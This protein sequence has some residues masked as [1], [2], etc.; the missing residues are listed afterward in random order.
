MEVIA[1]VVKSI[2]SEVD[3]ISKGGVECIIK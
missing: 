2:N 3:S 1:F